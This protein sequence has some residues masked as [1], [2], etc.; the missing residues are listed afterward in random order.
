MYKIKKSKI[1]ATV[2]KHG[3][4]LLGRVLSTM[5]QCLLYTTKMKV[6]ELC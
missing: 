2:R 3:T 5:D 6:E 4:R 1:R